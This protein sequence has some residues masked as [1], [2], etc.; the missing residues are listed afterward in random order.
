MITMK[1]ALML[2]AGLAEAR[3]VFETHSCCKEMSEHGLALL[4]EVARLRKLCQDVAISLQQDIWEGALFDPKQ[5][6]PCVER[7]ITD[8]IKGSKI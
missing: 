3:D 5:T 7:A 2:A 4:D 1:G 8:L 6:A